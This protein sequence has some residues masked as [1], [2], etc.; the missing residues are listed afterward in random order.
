MTFLEVLWKKTMEEPASDCRSCNARQNMPVIHPEIVT[1][2]NLQVETG[3]LTG[4]AQ[5]KRRR[6]LLDHMKV[7]KIQYPVS[8]RN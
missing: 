5:K 1:Y 6:A 2:Q 7:S 8:L 3:T 4:H